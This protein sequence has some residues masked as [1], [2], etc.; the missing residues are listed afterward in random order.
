MITTENLDTL[1]S[2]NAAVIDPSGDKIGSV[3][4]IFLDEESGQP[5]WVTVKTGLFGMSESFVP[6][7]D[8]TVQGNDIRV[9]S[10][11]ATVKD[12]PR[13]DDEDGRISRSQENELYRYYGLTAGG[14]YGQTDAPVGDT[15]QAP[16]TDTDDS[17]TRSEERLHVGT[18]STETGRV[19]LRKYIVTENVT[20]TVPVSHEEVRLEREP[21]TESNVGDA[22]SGPE[23]T[24]SEHE[25]TLH[26]ERPVVEK[27]TVPV[28][29]VRLDKDTVTEEVPVNEEV[30]REEVE[31]DDSSDA[32]GTGRNRL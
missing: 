32:S 11:K 15:R 24:E 2:G 29:K 28:E 9:S 14:S 31:I 10:D 8:A 30:R 26:A 12:A 18:E 16:V 21:I 6:L 19:R 17:M 5:A 20:R 7:A 22:L 3:G 1:L 25:V 23:L 13:I 4:Q 27:E